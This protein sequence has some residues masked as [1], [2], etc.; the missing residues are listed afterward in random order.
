[1]KNLI[2]RDALFRSKAGESLHL[3]RLS[4][5]IRDFWAV[6]GANGSGKKIFSSVL[7][8]RLSPLSGEYC[9]G[10]HRIRCLSFEA[11][12]S[13][14]EQT[15]KERNNDMCAPEDFGK[16]AAQII[17]SAG[18]DKEACNHYAMQL[19]IGGL[20]ERPFMHL[21]SG[22]SRKVLLAQAL[23]AQPDL[24]ILNDPFEGLDE[25][26]V[27][28]WLQLLTALKGKMAIVLILSRLAD[29]PSIADYIALLERHQLVLQGT[30]E[31]IENEEIF[32]QL[33]HG[34]LSLHSA[35]PE[36]IDTFPLPIAGRNT[37]EL[38]GLKIQYGDKRILD[39]LSWSVAPGQNWWIKGPNG[40]GKSTLLSVINADHPQAYANNVV[41]F[42]KARGS[43]ESIWE[44]KRN[45]GYLSSQLHMDYRVSC[46]AADVIL[47]GF[48]D[49]IGIYR[50]VPEALKLK[51]RQWLERLNMQALAQQ[52]F[53]S[54]SW[55]QQRL[56]L[57]AR[58]MV[59]HPPLLILDE[60]MQ[61]LDALNRKLIKVF[62]D[63]LIGNSRT[64]LLLV[65]HQNEDVPDCITHVLEFVPCA[66]GYRYCMGT[67]E[68]FMEQRISD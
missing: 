5:G 2:A 25:K 32:Q 56:L 41:L 34:E 39:N 63:Q 12:Q 36:S 4:I 19:N 54:L 22:E 7:E 28:Q 16:T 29:I 24:L 42:G 47:S 48:F 64:Q 59:K 67:Y 17:L 8:D 14:L 51:T 58:A 20:L 18:G 53:R 52:P 44:I 11:Q 62:I 21:S 50:Q 31:R 46:T 27:Q 43:G 33:R 68:E 57:I 10:F 23:V 37:F 30:K 35:L 65:S 38:Q 49:S 66:Q 3:P 40:A 1:M 15:F 61:G 13:I 60:P 9:N 45:I 6:V 26:S 55:G